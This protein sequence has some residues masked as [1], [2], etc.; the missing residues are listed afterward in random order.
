M[1][2]VLNTSFDPHFCALFNKKSQLLF[3][4]HWHTPK[5]DGQRIWDFLNTHLNPAQSLNFIGGVSGPG[6]FSSLRTG[7]VILNAL[8]FR[9]EILLH[10]ARADRVI[11]DFLNSQNI[12]VPF[13]LNSFSDRVFQLENQ[14]LKAT[15]INHLELN[16]NQTIITAWLPSQKAERFKNCITVDPLGPL[17][18]LLKTLE[19]TT[20]QNLFIP[21]YEYPAVQ[22]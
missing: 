15:D 10:Q 16:K 5:E 7:G 19:K 18:T 17:E 21:D 12:N 3:A 14:N 13:L 8:A 11:L 9:F 4:T 22:T 1:K 6:S 2:F 20:P